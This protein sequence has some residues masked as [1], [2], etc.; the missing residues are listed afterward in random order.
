MVTREKF[1]TI[2]EMYWNINKL[3]IAQGTHHYPMLVTMDEGS[4]FIIS[5]EKNRELH[6]TAKYSDAYI[7]LSEG[8]V[9]EAW[10]DEVGKLHR[11]EVIGE[12]LVMQA[13]HPQVEFL[14]YVSFEKCADSDQIAFFDDTREEK[15]PC[16]VA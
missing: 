13:K 16:H 12:R 2:A 14:R 11:G 6:R 8:T 4:I 15:R 7:W 9:R 3:A 5:A 10:R 1:E